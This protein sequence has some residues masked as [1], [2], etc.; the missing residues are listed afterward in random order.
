MTQVVSITFFFLWSSIISLWLIPSVHALAGGQQQQQQQQ[1][2]FG[3]DN[4]NDIRLKT[5]QTTLQ[6]MKRTMHPEF[7]ACQEGVVL[8]DFYNTFADSSSSSSSSANI[9]EVAPS[10]IPKAGRGVFATRIIPAGTIVSLY[11][12][13]GVGVDFQQVDDNDD[14]DNNDNDTTNIIVAL[15]PTDQEFFLQQQQQESSKQAYNYL[16]YLL[17]SRPL[18]GEEQVGTG[19]TNEQQNTNAQLFEGDALFIDVNP[20][21]PTTSGWV[22]HFINDGAIVHSNS[23]IGVLDYYAESRKAKNCVHVPFGPSP[24]LATVTTKQIEKGQELFTSYGCM[25]WLQEILTTTSILD[26][27]DDDGNDEEEEYTDITETIQLKVKETTIDL[28]QAMQSV[29][30]CYANEEK[31]FHAAF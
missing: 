25:Y 23:E 8:K 18:G 5:I 9:I 19:A 26:D 6:K 4:V 13:H 20:N 2:P 29:R 1:R 22:S 7:F 30:T 27:G 10:S 17:G 31:A 3:L 24:I 12:C 16:H 15:D 28:F 14:D 21:Q 11:P